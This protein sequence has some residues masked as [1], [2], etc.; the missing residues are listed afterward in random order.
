MYKGEKDFDTLYPLAYRLPT[1]KAAKREVLIGF[2]F[3]A[4]T[5]A[6]AYRQ[7]T[8]FDADEEYYTLLGGVY[9]PR[10]M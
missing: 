8:E 3:D 9:S 2:I 4:V 1:G 6:A 10:T 5:A 7:A